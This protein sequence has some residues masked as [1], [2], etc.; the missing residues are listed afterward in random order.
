MSLFDK[1]SGSPLEFSVA[2]RGLAATE[3]DRRRPVTP[4]VAGASFVAR[5]A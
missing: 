4:E 3:V 2:E 1:Q 5:A